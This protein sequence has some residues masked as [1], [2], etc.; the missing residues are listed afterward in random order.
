MATNANALKGLNPFDFRASCKLI[1]TK[2]TFLVSC[3]AGA[4]WRLWHFWK[5]MLTLPL[6]S[7]L[8]KLPIMRPCLLAAGPLS[9]VAHFAYL[10]R[11]NLSSAK[12]YV[13]RG[14]DQSASPYETQ[15]GYCAV[16]LKPHCRVNPSP[17]FQPL[18]VSDTGFPSL[19]LFQLIG[20][21]MSVASSWPQGTDT[22]THCRETGIFL[23]GGKLAIKVPSFNGKSPSN[24]S[25]GPDALYLLDN[26][27]NILSKKLCKF[28][29]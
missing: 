19:I 24:V 14:Q 29:G 15:R 7:I 10:L 1:L 12:K 11:F 3:L 20:P 18:D 26:S 4:F 9:S 8:L 16:V 28:S 22:E 21:M 5:V 13:F 27:S 17:S 2:K 25:V 23:F 6:K